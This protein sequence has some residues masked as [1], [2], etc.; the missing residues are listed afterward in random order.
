MNSTVSFLAVVQVVAKFI[1]PLQLKILQ[2]CSN[3]DVS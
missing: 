3:I 1:V 2:T